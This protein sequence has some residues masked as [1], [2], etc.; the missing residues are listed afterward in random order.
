[1]VF[2]A[3]CRLTPEIVYMQTFFCGGYKAVKV[4]YILFSR[5]LPL[6]ARRQYVFDYCTVFM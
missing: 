2:R 4:K 6:N 1:M 5:T 3:P